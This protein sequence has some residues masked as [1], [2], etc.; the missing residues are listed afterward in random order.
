MS[1][2][3][4][5]LDPS[6][7]RPH[8]EREQ[9]TIVRFKEQVRHA[10]TKSDYFSDLLEHIDPESIVDRQSICQIPV[11]RKSDLK[12]IQGKAPPFGGLT[13]APISGLARVF[14]SPGPIY[15]PQAID[16]DFW[17]FKRALYAVGVR[18]GS[19]VY[20][21]F[22][23]HFTPAG[24]MADFGARALGCAVFPAGIGQTE[25]QARTISEIR[26]DVYTG[27]PSFLKILLEKGKE[28][29]LDLSSLKRGI[30]GGE[31]FLPAARQ[32]FQ[33]HGIK[34]CQTYATAD[35]GL[36]AYETNPDDGLVIDEDIYVEIV[37]PGSNDIVPDG[38][39]GEVVVSMFSSIYPLIRFG[40]G[41]L[42]TFIPGRSLCGRT[43][44][45]LKGWMGR[46]DQ[47]T[48]VKGMFV[49]PEQINAVIARHPEITYARLN[50]K[51]DAQQNDMMTLDCEV[52]SVNE[53]LEAAIVVSIRD[54]TKLRGS[55]NL[56]KQETL[57]RDGKVIDDQ[58]KYD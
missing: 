19:L 24:F 18:P 57:P 15:E 10:Q 32:L 50:V 9:E 51:H 28:L 55:V 40:T 48:K 17:R 45:R 16:E 2:S 26:P 35:V 52:Q 1:D 31:A 38:E 42:S 14:S 7:T 43:N 54:V 20:N 3:N 4:S 6:E 58:R 36:I 5:F 53:G 27:T 25:L 21:T 22:S 46:A 34:V 11:T 29:G 47:T 23:Y 8:D 49:H 39:V 33:E 41:D 13:T 44:R 30:V 37:R 12:S 56:V